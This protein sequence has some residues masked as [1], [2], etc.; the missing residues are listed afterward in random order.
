[1][2]PA[3]WS[4]NDQSELSFD[5]FDDNGQFAGPIPVGLAGAQW[6][7]IGGGYDLDLNPRR[8]KSPPLLHGMVL[9]KYDT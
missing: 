2:Y 5:D 8:A 4:G 3:P 9:S 1:M 7:R 6:L